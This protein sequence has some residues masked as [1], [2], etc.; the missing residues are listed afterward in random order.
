MKET[1]LVT[2]TDSGSGL[3]VIRSLG[4]K[5]IP[6]IAGSHRS[7]AMGFRS[8]YCRKKLVYPDPLD[9]EEA[10]IEKLLGKFSEYGMIIPIDDRTVVPLSKYKKLFEERGVVIPI[11]SYD[12]VRTA[13][14]KDRTVEVAKKLNIPCPSTRKASSYWD[15]EHIIPELKFPIAVKPII[16]R[17]D[18]K[19]FFAKDEREL[20]E[21]VNSSGIPVEELLFQEFIPGRDNVY[22]VSAVFDGNHQP[23][24]P[25]T[26]RKIREWPP[27]TGGTCVFGETMAPFE[28]TRLG[29]NLLTGINWYGMV[30]AE[31]KIDSR[32]QVPKL[33][34]V[35]PRFFGYHKL[36]IQAGID[37]P[38]IL[39][40]L[41]LGENL[42][43]INAYKVGLRF[44]R[45]A[46]DLA[47]TILD[48]YMHRET[49]IISD[50]INSYITARKKLTFDVMAASDLRPVVRYYI[51]G[52]KILWRLLAKKKVLVP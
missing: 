37:Y 11:A 46:E 51:N 29:L 33:M 34:E 43:V 2:C 16:N 30:A 45:F 50:F 1:V 9:Q 52:F 19:V 22:T 35:N 12:E 18:F 24:A 8:K 31:F 14:E 44:S 4:E 36:A 13:H 39:Y 15:L 10:F 20:K 6:I 17:E 7:D 23:I 26:L 27:D 28:V 3:A 5:N 41:A 25:V 38:Y 48:Y 40:R 42:P 49:K 47:T 32:D 21:F